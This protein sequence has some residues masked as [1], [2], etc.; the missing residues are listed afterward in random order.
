MSA[1]IFSFGA[2]AIVTLLVS[3]GHRRH[4]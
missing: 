1:S 4:T 2:A 3:I